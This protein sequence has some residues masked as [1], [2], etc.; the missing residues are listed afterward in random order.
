MTDPPDGSST[1]EAM[2]DESIDRFLVDHRATDAPS[3]TWGRQF[4]AGLAWVHFRPGNGGL[5]VGRGHQERVNR[6]LR[7]A[8]IPNNYLENFVGVGTA[9]P[10]IE[11]W[12]SAAQQHRLLRPLF[13]CEEIWCQLFSEP[14]AGS[15]LASLSTSAVRDG[16]EWVIDGHKV[17]TTMGHIA[18]W[19]ILIARTDPTMPKHKGLTYFLADMT[20]PGVEVRPL[21]QISGEAEFNEVFFDEVRVPDAMR[22]GEPGEGWRVTISTLMNERAH[23]GDSAKLPRG[24]GIIAYALRLWADHPAQD[25]VRRDRLTRLWIEAEVTRL[26]ALRAGGGDGAAPGPEASVLKLAVGLLPQRIFE[27]CLEL[28]GP[29]GQLI[30]DYDFAQPTRTGEDRMGDGSEEINVQKAFINARSTTIG[31]GT[32]EMQKN[33][34]AE[35]MLGLPGEPRADRDLP[36]NEVPR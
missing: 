26:T 30:G 3:V 35:R 6:R 34:I 8:D 33:A 1:D 21:R 27:F 17:W 23:N 15:D 4:D 36:W 5:G 10:T 12:G 19:G 31:G 7:D 29:E 25:P 11:A 28:M 24:H 18:R 13:T 2:V 20:A 32:T 9:A 14:G 22:L 16:D